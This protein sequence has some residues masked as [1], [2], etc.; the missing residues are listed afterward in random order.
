MEVG[1]TPRQ[2]DKVRNLQR[3]VPR[4]DMRPCS[5][6]RKSGRILLPI[7]RRFPLAAALPF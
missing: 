3:D 2:L 1:A 5:P 4:R 7:R 6:S